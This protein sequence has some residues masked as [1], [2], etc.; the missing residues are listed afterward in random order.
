MKK[1]ITV[2]GACA[3]EMMGMYKR[4]ELQLTICSWKIKPV[5]CI[6]TRIVFWFHQNPVGIRSLLWPAMRRRLQQHLVCLCR[7]IS[8][9]TPIVRCLEVSTG[10][11]ASRSPHF[12]SSL[13]RPPLTSSGP[14]L[15]MNRRE[16]PPHRKTESLGVGGREGPVACW[17]YGTREKSKCA[18]L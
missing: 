16:R 3:K 12:S 15:L 18:F 10:E 13:E 2:F 5:V 9:C 7:L 17:R 4:D 11:E 1:S 14:L 8:S 6:K